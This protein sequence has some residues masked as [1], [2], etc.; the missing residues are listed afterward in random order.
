VGSRHLIA[1]APGSYPPH[2]QGRMEG[3][4]G[5]G[6]LPGRREYETVRG[7]R[8]ARD[9]L[10]DP[11]LT[12]EEFTTWWSWEGIF[13]YDRRYAFTSSA[14]RQTCLVLENH[15]IFSVK[16]SERVQGRATV[17][18]HPGIQRC[19]GRAGGGS[20]RRTLPDVM[21]TLTGT[22]LHGHYALSAS[23]RGET[24]RCPM[25]MSIPDSRSAVRDGFF[26]G[27]C[28]VKDRWPRTQ[29]PAVPRPCRDP[30]DLQQPT[31]GPAPTDS[32]RLDSITLL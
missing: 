25:T 27:Q 15:P 26:K 10:S 1:K 18:S 22:R 17:W 20:V 5:S 16:P 31:Y 3:R 2:R 30:D 19:A 28:W 4:T 24:Y 14:G 6:C 29:P 8:A 21:R 7:R 32:D 11:N 13:R 9:S 23:R 12:I